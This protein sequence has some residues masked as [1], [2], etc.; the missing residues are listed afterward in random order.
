MTTPNQHD[1]LTQIYD[2]I[3][4]ALSTDTRRVV[5]FNSIEEP[6]HD[7]VKSEDLPEWQVRPGSMQGI[8]GD[9][10][11]TTELDVG[12]QVIINT[13][14]FIAGKGIF[15]MQWEL[16]KRLNHLKYSQV[17]DG[18]KYNGHGFV[19]DCAIA[20]AV[21]GLSDPTA[22]GNRGIAGWTAAWDIIV[23]CSFLKADLS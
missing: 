16:L 4:K 6:L 19:L 11:G 23:K 20:T 1:P 12:Y 21:Q 17:L 5:S 10:S 13:G 9:T 2:A 15:P 18:L 8:V 7:V 3:V 22:P 14:S